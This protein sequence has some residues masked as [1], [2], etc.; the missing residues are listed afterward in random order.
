M[1]VLPVSAAPAIELSPGRGHVGTSV[2]IEGSGFVALST[3]TLTFDKQFIPTAPETI[4]VDALGKFEAAFQVPNSADAGENAV[5]ATAEIVL[6]NEDDGE[7]DDDEKDDDKRRDHDDRDDDEKERDHDDKERDKDDDRNN[8]DEKDDE[9]EKDDGKGRDHDDNPKN[10]LRSTASST[11]IVVT[12][13]NNA[14][15][16]QSVSI[17][18]S[19]ERSTSIILEGSDADGD[20]ISFSIVDDPQHGKLSELNPL[21]GTVT[22]HPSRD[23]HGRDSFSFKVNDGNE[24]SEPATVTID[25]ASVNDSPNADYVTVETKEDSEVRINLTGSDDESPAVSFSV[26]SDPGHGNLSDITS[27]GSNSAEITYTPKPDY[28]GKD[29]FEISVSDSSGDN[30]TAKVDITVIPVN[31]APVAA[32]GE[33]KT[34]KGEFVSFS[35]TASDVDGDKLSYVIIA[36]PSHGALS[37]TAPNLEYT[38]SINYHGSDE[39]TFKVNDGT[40]DSN[41]ARVAITIASLTTHSRSGGGSSDAIPAVPDDTSVDTDLVLTEAT[42]LPVSDGI[43]QYFTDFI[44]TSQAISPGTNPFHTIVTGTEITETT[45]NQPP[46]LILPTSPLEVDATSALGA[47]VSYSVMALDDFDGEI[48]PYCSPES[49]FEFPV[50]TVNVVCRVADRAGNTALASF[51]VAVK[52]IAQ[53]ESPSVLIPFLIMGLVGAASFGGFWAL[54]R[55]RQE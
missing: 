27:T 4:I 26:N 38:P 31:D 7:K 32:S 24:D 49:G 12:D 37:G 45:D 44:R 6:D 17:T 11:F 21:M 48:N 18:I 19:E 33:I 53:E 3:V 47:S 51:V 16:A 25:I 55:A 43:S 36:N 42:D 34:R 41:T 30:D 8:D 10:I 1:Y 9:D 35:I 13:A 40:V 23:Y 46:K 54:A 22:Y 2:D 20:A 14:P 29:S 28:N 15:V 5:V 39:F 50:G 52:L